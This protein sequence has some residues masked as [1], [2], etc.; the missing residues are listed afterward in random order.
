[1]CLKNEVDDKAVSGISLYGMYVRYVQYKATLFTG[2]RSVSSFWDSSRFFDAFY[3][4]ESV[5]GKKE[6]TLKFTS[7]GDLIVDSLFMYLDM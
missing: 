5:L 6:N 7:P 3:S 2:G 4:L 1:M